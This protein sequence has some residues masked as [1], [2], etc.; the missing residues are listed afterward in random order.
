[1]GVGVGVGVGGGE[2]GY[3]GIPFKIDQEPPT[4]KFTKESPAI[5]ILVHF[6][7]DS[8]GKKFLQGNPL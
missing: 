8:P 5:L 2:G 1:M 3:V 6:T 7:K 4:E